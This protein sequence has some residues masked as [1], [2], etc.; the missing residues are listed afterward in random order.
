MNPYEFVD[1]QLELQKARTLHKHLQNRSWLVLDVYVLIAIS[2]TPV[3]QTSIGLLS[4]QVPKLMW[5]G[6]CRPSP[7]YFVWG[8]DA[9]NHACHEELIYC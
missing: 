6:Q 7:G 4:M 3:T 2:R 8:N 5:R 9:S 1:P